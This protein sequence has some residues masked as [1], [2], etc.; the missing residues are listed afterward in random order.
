MKILLMFI[1]LFSF[2]P[3]SIFAQ[4]PYM[5]NPG[6]I[7]RISVWNEAE[8]QLET[9][10]LPDGTLSFPLVG[11]VQASSKTPEEVEK[12]VKNKLSRVIPDPEVNVSVVSVTG[13]NIFV[14]GQ[15]NTP[16]QIPLTRETDV[17]QALS[18]AGGFTGFAQSDDIRILR[19]MKSGQKI[20]EFDYTK[21]EEGKALETNILLKSGDT[22]V[23]P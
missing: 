14:I 21:I 7:V 13:N 19:R 4:E 17:V 1:G 6:D 2:F 16:G 10:I 9:M 23:V 18:L 12:T 20:I 5:L 22:I 8:L 15:V 3:G 11:T